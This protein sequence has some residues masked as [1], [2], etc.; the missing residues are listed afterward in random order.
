MIPNTTSHPRMAHNPPKA[1][2]ARPLGQ[3]LVALVLGFSLFAALLALLPGAYARIYDGR[4]FPGVTVGGVD[5]SGL[6]TQQAAS[7]LTQ[8][9]DYPKRGKI[10]LQEG[11]H[12]WTATPGDLGLFL[13]AQTTALAAY[14]L[15][16]TGD[17]STRL[18][19]QWRAWSQGI[20]LP[21][22]FV[23]DKRIGQ[24]YLQ[25]IAEQVDRPI[26]EAS[27]GVNG[28]EVEV[29][30]GQVGRSLDIDAALNS[31]DVQ[32]KTLTDGLVPLVVHETPPV[33]LDAE[34]EAKQ[35]R[36]ILS[37]ALVLQIPN[38]EQ[39]DPGPWSFEPVALA[40]M[41]TIQ[42][43]KTD[44]AETYQVG[45]NP[46]ALRN[47]L[48]NIAP[49]LSRNP[50]NARFIFNDDTRKLEVIQSAVIGRALDVDASLAQ[51]NQQILAGQHA[52]SLVMQTTNPAATDSTT[53]ESLGITELTSSYTSYFY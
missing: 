15:G 16:R 43:I 11:S 27:L 38:P 49:G 12:L 10:V 30:S 7:L 22:W 26:I 6:S 13:D 36:Q 18:A 8:Q 47:F 1:S 45:L 48:L 37:A 25:G 14:N 53:G 35:A 24:Y 4:I 46:D 20:T 2:I 3:A 28:M 40:Q 51:I 44:T 17:L 34:A 52:V 5:V 32:M 41:L 42:R 19:D 33:I 50:Q 31:L 9:L 39:G 21:P 23:F 29:H